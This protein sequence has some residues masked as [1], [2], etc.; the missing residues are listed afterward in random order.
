MLYQIDEKV[1][2]VS[3]DILDA[4]FFVHSE[5]GPGL[6]ESVYEKCLARKLE[7]QGL[8]VESQKIL[9]V[10]FD[11]EKIECGFRIDLFV[12]NCVI[13]ELKACDKIA[14]IHEAQLHSYLKLSNLTLGLLLNFNETSLKNGIKR[15]AIA[16]NI[17]ENFV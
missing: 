2:R 10:Y 11:G 17:K 16:Q 3:K 12:E 7:K 14:P 8:V 6:L 13:V 4:A 1:N 15:I 9:P 5:L